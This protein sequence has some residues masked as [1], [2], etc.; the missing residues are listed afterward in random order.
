VLPT[1]FIIGAAKAGTTSL[2][3]YLGLHPEI[4]MSSIKEP[5]FFA[6]S[7]SAIPYPVSRVERREDYERLFETDLRVRGE[8]SPSYTQYARRTGVPE[9][10]KEAVPDAKLLYVVRD[11]IARTISHYTHW[12]AI[13]LEN[14]P[15]RDALAD[16]ESLTNIYTCGGRYA[17]QLEQYLHHFEGDN[18]VVLDQHELRRDRRS[19]LRRAYSFLDVD[20]DFSSLEF[21]HELNVNR[22]TRGTRYAKLRRGAAKGAT[23]ILPT[24]IRLQ[25]RHAVEAVET[26][27]LP[28][29]EPPELDDDLRARLVELYA[30]EVERLRAHT[31]ENFASWSV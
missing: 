9:R 5:H 3:Y 22:V 2:S 7:A 10:I 18:L 25:L 28:K 19:V 4:H 24:S 1:F 27:F 30:P 21:D 15:L 17:T 26:R 20:A 12:R 29:D 16:A 8:A 14:R 11:P 31:G 23:A 13:G 6:G